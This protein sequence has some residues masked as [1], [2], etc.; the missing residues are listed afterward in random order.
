[1]KFKSLIALILFA[2]LLPF[3]A[4]S[5]ALSLFAKENPSLFA[6]KDP[7][8]TAKE[9]NKDAAAENKKGDQKTP[10]LDQILANYYKAIGGL[11]KWQKLDTMI[12]KG[13]MTSQGV[14]MPITAYH[15][16]PNNCRVEFRIEENL[17]AQVFNGM[18]AW[19]LNPLSGNPDPSPMSQSRSNYLRDTCDI[20]SSLIDYKK[21]GYDVRYLGEEEVAG[22]KAYKVTVNYKSGNIETHFLDTETYL[23]IKVE[24]IYNLEGNEMR[25]TTNYADFKNTNGYVVPYNLAID[26]HG[27]PSTENLKIDKFIFNSK[28]NPTMFDFPKDKIVDLRKEKID[29]EKMQKK[30]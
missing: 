25:T 30:E 15:K 10:D 12:M 4:F 29:L 9:S 1:M 26:I 20:E 7:S 5:E 22:R 16:R 28:I 18:F 13:T 8:P 3:S 11:E 6:K 24:G 19:Q 23:I 21:K 2:I 14:S 17:L 27:A